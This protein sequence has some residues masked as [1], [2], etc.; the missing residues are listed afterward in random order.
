MDIDIV[1]V[2]PVDAK[3]PCHLVEL[4]VRGLAG[5]LDFGQFTQELPGQPR[6]NWQVAYDERVLNDDGTG[7]LGHRF[8]FQV[9]CKGDLRV[10]FFFH[11]LDV[12]RPLLA[13][14]GS[15]QL[16][17]PTEMPARLEFFNYEPPQ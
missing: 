17:K 1:G 15:I 7:A 3:E 16:P 5:V 12:S 11:Y 14:T 4:W 2:Y 9:A 8:P 13:P 6:S 10:G